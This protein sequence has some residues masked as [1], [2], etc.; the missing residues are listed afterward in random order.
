ML[1]VDDKPDNRC[2]LTKLLL[3]LGFDVREAANGR[4]AL[5]LWKEF[6]P[7]LIWMDMRMPVIDGYNATREIRNST[8][9]AK[10]QAET[11]H[12]PIIALTA[13]SFEEDR[14]LILS[15]GCDDYICKP[16]QEAD[17]F[18]IMQKY[19][20]IRYVYDEYDG[21]KGNGEKEQ[22]TLTSA[23]LS[24]LPEDLYRSLRQAVEMGDV[25]V[26]E[27]LIT[28]IKLQNESMAEALANL[29]K[30]FRFDLLQEFFM[31]AGQ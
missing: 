11:R 19:L 9:C 1:V 21:Q 27:H 18:A 20:G 16:F 7:H 12:I 26:A 4:E 24:T 10:S 31:G 25:E 14:A 8:P 15:A 30:Q 29:V 2:L 17:I 13:S 22:L 23:M 5:D 3:P 6:E 28:Q